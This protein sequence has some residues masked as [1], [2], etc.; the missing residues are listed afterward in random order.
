MPSC[1]PVFRHLILGSGPA[2]LTA[3]LYAAR[4]N[5]CPLI[6]QGVTPGGQ[7][8]KTTSVDNYPGF[9]DGIQGP[10]L[11][12]E[13]ERQAR[14]FG[15]NIV[16]GEVTAVDL[17]KAPFEAYVGKTCYR[18]RTLIVATGASPKMLGLP[19]ERELLGRGVSVCATCDAFFYKGKKVV[20]V[21]GGDTAMGEAA[22]IARFAREVMVVHRG[23]TLRAVPPMK[24]R[25]R[26]NKRVSFRLHTMLTEILGDKQSGVRGVR[27]KDLQSGQQEEIICDG[28]F[29]AIGHRPNTALFRGQLELD[30][31]GYIVSRNFTETSVPGVFAAGDVQ[32]RVFRQAVT[33]AG[34]GCMAAMQA[35]RYLESQ[36]E[37][38]I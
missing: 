18:G 28:V 5:C 37:E 16:T 11:M 4:S 13:M 17:S 29:I 30:P 22:F 25:A 20:V 3:G 9:P 24:E 38:L 8:T 12:A 19:N 10:E 31:E 21:G 14:R 32:D 7:L 34:S 27:V 33:A 6:I 23:E 36:E 2:G 35:E 26:K 15:T 1:D